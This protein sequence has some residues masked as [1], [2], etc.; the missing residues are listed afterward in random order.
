M[1]KKKQDK[2]FLM[3]TWAFLISLLVLLGVSWAVVEMIVAIMES[4]I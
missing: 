4:L 3:R 1:S 2:R